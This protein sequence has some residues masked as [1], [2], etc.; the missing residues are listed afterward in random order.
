MARP[1]NKL[2]VLPDN[3]VVSIA[4]SQL[5]AYLTATAEGVSTS[6]GGKSLGTVDLTLAAITQDNAK[7]VLASMFPEEVATVEAPAMT[8][9]TTTGSAE[10]IVEPP[11]STETT[12]S[13]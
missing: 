5:K 12:A 4:P 9:G 2:V 7:A 8:S 10:S 11:A 1:K 13:V 6:L 3:S